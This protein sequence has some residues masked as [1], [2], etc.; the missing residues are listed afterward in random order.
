MDPVLPMSEA[1]MP[2]V[3]KGPA[4]PTPQNQYDR[5]PSGSP[6]VLWPCKASNT[7]FKFCDCVVVGYH[8]SHKP[9]AITAT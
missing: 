5:A 2:G 1:C 9:I 7:L 3:S 6:I 4:S 8:W